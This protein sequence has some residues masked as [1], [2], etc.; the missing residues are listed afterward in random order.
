MKKTKERS[1]SDYEEAVKTEVGGAV[2]C[3]LFV[4]RWVKLRLSRMGFEPMPFRTSTWNWRLRPTRPSWLYGSW[5]SQVLI[6]TNILGA[7]YCSKILNTLVLGVKPSARFSFMAS[8]LI[9]D[10]FVILCLGGGQ[11]IPQVK[12]NQIIN[13]F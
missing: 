2:D 7:Y 6:E 11:T 5:Q 9:C 12:V 10:Y 1:W 4:L 8:I 13:D 3:S